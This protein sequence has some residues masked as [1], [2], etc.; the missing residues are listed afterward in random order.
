MQFDAARQ[1]RL[2]LDYIGTMGCGLKSAIMACA[3][4][5]VGKLMMV[6]VGCR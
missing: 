3:P 6:A 2:R 4:R 1:R 5:Q